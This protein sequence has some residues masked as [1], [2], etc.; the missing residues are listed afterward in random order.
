MHT[1][2]SPLVLGGSS[3]WYF[4]ISTGWD[5]PSGTK[6]IRLPLLTICYRIFSPTLSLLSSHTSLFSHT[7]T[8]EPGAGAE[9]HQPPGRLG[10]AQP[11]HMAVAS[12]QGIG[13]AASLA[14]RRGG[15]R[16]SCDICFLFLFLWDKPYFDFVECVIPIFV[17]S[18]M[19]NVNMIHMIM[20]MWSLLVWLVIGVDLFWEK[21]TAGWFVPREKYG[22]LVADK[23][24]E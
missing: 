5:C 23:P 16:C 7:C 11:P 19:V 21:S 20:N 1:L 24:N 15:V 8:Q 6:S 4:P 17:R 2:W 9:A 13:H 12:C 14:Q 18:L 22:W 10:G 3:T